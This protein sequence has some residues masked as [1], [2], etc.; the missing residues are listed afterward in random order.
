VEF[1]S[2]DST[3]QPRESTGLKYRT[4]T[5]V[6]EPPSIS[7]GRIYGDAQGFGRVRASTVMLAGWEGLSRSYFYSYPWPRPGSSVGSPRTAGGAQVSGAARLR[8]IPL[9]GLTYNP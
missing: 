6:E 2:E 1:K 9:L 7:L 8:A 4:S 3:P 5:C